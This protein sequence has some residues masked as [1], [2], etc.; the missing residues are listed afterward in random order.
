MITPILVLMM[1]IV[2][3][4][5]LVVATTTLTKSAQSSLIVVTL[6]NCG[7]QTLKL[8]SPTNF[9]GMDCV[10][11]LYQCG[12]QRGKWKPPVP[13]RAGGVATAIELLP[14]KSVK[15]TSIDLKPLISKLGEVKS[16]LTVKVQYSN[17]LGEREPVTGV[18]TGTITGSPKTVPL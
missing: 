10:T 17:Q 13:P 18:W 3:D 1:A 2:P 11:I 12:D 6:K 9:E 7:E 14:G 4:T 8:W 15:L 16:Q 5:P